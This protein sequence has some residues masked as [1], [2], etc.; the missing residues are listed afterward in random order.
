[1]MKPAFNEYCGAIRLPHL[2]HIPESPLLSILQ[3]RQYILSHSHFLDLLVF[4]TAF[5]VFFGALAFLASGFLA[6]D[7]PS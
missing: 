4:L 6:F 5:F 3:L 7:T 2:S 1:M